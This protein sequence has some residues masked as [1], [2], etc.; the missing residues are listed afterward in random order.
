MSGITKDNLTF[1]GYEYKVIITNAEKVSFLIDV[2]KNFGWIVDENIKN[3]ISRDISNLHANIVLRLKR[4]RKIINKMELTRLQRN[5]EFCMKEIDYLEKSKT[6]SATIYALV[7]GSIGTAFMAGS[8]FAVTATSPM[9]V[10]SIFLAIPAFAGWICPYY[11]YKNIVKKRTEK[12]T[13]LIEEKQDEIYE[14][15]KK[16]N[17]LLN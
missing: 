2:Y 4:G 11:I 8:V 12:V 13:S 6:S 17:K 15:C 1:V 3:N 14:I 10:L 7:V 5:F 9:I 16:G